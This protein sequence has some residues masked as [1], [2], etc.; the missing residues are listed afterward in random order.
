VFV[1]R[2]VVVTGVGVVSPLALTAEESWQRVVRG[3]SGIGAITLFDATSYPARIAGEVKSFDPIN[4]M[5]KK[6]V[7]KMDRFIQ[8]ATAAAQEA[9]AMSGLAI[10]PQNAERVGVAVGSGIGGLA[11]LEEQHKILLERGPGR[12]SPFFIPGMIINMASGQISIRYGAKGPN[13]ATVT[14]CS[15]A[16]H[17]IGEATRYIQRGEADAMICGG[18]EAAVSPL[19]VAG[20]SAMRALSTRN[21]EPQRAS[22]P[23]DSQRDGF[24]MGEGAGVLVV[25]SLEHA[26]A[27]GAKILCE[28][29]GYGLSGDAYH[30]SAPSEDGDG[31][32]RVMANAVRDAGLRL[33][34]VHYINAHGTATTVGDKVE[35]LAI[36][37]LFGDHARSL[38]VSS[39]KSMTGHLLGAAGGLEAVL[40]IMAIRDQK[41]PP[42]IN[43]ENPDPDCDLDYVPNA[44]R[45]MPIR[46]A[47]SNSFG[48]GGTNAC[49]ALARY[50]V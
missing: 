34:D 25:E 3:E 49:L 14:A 31:P 35:T 20:F 22:R 12:V 48:F 28:V 30:I 19:A 9:V 42:T 32:M 11:L 43:L 39:T 6:D 2:R 7:K 29:L 36:K 16:S 13:I 27:R 15:T 23:Y 38:A 41:A 8:F 5:D 47:L 18:T 33:E 50:E 10:T 46:Y 40:T 17:A 45:S 21:D 44:A 4:Y 1:K 26:Q 37:R 24:V